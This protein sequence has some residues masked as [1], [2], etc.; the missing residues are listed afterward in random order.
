MGGSECYNRSQLGPVRDVSLDLIL[1]DVAPMIRR[2][3]SWISGV[4]PVAT[5]AVP[6]KTT[7]GYG[8][9]V[10]WTEKA[11]GSRCPFCTQARVAVVHTVIVSPLQ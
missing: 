9:S 3:A 4:S 1:L 2:L 8:A 6:R 10:I 5:L 11:T 7:A